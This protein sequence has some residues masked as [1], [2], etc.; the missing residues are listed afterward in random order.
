MPD[1]ENEDGEKRRL[2][3]QSLIVAIEAGVLIRHIFRLPITSHHLSVWCCGRGHDW[4][5]GETCWLQTGGLSVPTSMDGGTPAR[6]WAKDAGDRR[7][8]SVALVMAH[9]VWGSIYY[10]P[11]HWAILFC[12]A[13]T[14][15]AG[16]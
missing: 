15:V 4:K 11:G 12:N 10:E 9:V 13:G 3:P 1:L 2:A 5:V 6:S 14:A 16:K 7:D 8:C